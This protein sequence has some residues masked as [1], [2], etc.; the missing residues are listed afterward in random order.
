[1]SADNE[2]L[3]KAFETLIPNS[4]DD[5]IRQ[6]RDVASLRLTTDME[7]MSLYAPII[8][9]Q[10]KEFINDWRFIAFTL[11][12]AY[13]CSTEIFLLGNRVSDGNPRITSRVRKVDLDRGLVFTNSGSLYGL[14]S[15]GNGEPDQTQLFLVCAAFWKW[16]MGG[17]LGIMQIFY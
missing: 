10:V 9:G 16:G 6:H 11:K 4:L 7:V 2:A 8:P 13:S 17:E 1:M 14:G 15:P 3:L 5:I 12:N